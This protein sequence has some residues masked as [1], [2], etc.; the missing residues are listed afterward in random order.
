[1]S[2]NI[3]Y[4]DKFILL[5][6]EILRGESS[7][8]CK[9]HMLFINHVFPKWLTDSFLEVLTWNVNSR[10]GLWGMADPKMALI[11]WCDILFYLELRNLRLGTPPLHIQT[12]FFSYPKQNVLSL[13]SGQGET[14]YRLITNW[15][16]SNG[17]II[18]T[19][20]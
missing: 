18:L 15:D 8:L 11:S 6:W 12:H 9:C 5:A 17:L 4:H 20:W 10:F 14:P 2:L 13:K 7:D 19:A 16:I 3:I 1:M